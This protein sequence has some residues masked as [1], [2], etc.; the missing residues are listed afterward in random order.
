ME[1]LIIGQMNEATYAWQIWRKAGSEKC[2]GMWG[3]EDTIII[4]CLEH[5]KK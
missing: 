3:D 5:P 4:Q 1:A 2:P